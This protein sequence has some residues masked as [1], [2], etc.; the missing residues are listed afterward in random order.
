MQIGIDLGASKIEYVLMDDNGNEHQRERVEVPKDYKKTLII[1][2]DI[3]IELERKGFKT[4]L[5][6]RRV[7]DDKHKARKTDLIL[8]HI[9]LES[10]ELSEDDLIYALRVLKNAQKPILIHCWHGSDRTGATTAAYRIV[11]Q[12]WSKDDAIAELRRPE[13]GHHEDWYPNIIELLKNL[14]VEKMRAALKD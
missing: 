13:F 6:L 14:D 10:K 4:I 11:V 7:K 1:I 8:N 2:K 12:G 3:V 9:R 5:N